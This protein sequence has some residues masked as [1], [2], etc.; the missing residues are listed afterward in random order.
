ML[1]GL[2]GGGD[3]TP[4]KSSANRCGVVADQS[5]GHL[6]T[7]ISTQGD[8]PTLTLVSNGCYTVR[9]LINLKWLIHDQESLNYL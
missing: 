5:F 8:T 9:M 3:R 7:S 2:G 1:C 4:K 6:L